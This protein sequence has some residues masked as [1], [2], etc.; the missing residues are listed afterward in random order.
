MKQVGDVGGVMEGREIG[1]TERGRVKIMG[2]VD[3]PVSLAEMNGEG[4]ST[5]A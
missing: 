5:V 2:E 4:E 1:G 3:V